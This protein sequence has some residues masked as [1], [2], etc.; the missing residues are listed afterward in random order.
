MIINWK[1][2]F[3][4][5]F[6][7]CCDCFLFFCVCVLCDIAY[8]AD[9]VLCVWFIGKENNGAR[10]KMF[11]RRSWNTYNLQY[12][13]IMSLEND[14]FNNFFLLDGWCSA[15]CVIHTMFVNPIAFRDVCHIKMCKAT[16]IS[17][18]SLETIWSGDFSR[19]SIPANI[20]ENQEKSI[21]HWGIGKLA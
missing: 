9:L 20:V 21:N 4:T 19:D 7:C 18:W 5:I 13:S 8:Y 1:Q 10:W 11:T 15:A 2:F 12:R 3:H 17:L 6:C 14:L 16:A